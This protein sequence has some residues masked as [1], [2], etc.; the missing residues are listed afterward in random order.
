[1]NAIAVLALATVG[2]GDDG[3]DDDDDNGDSDAAPSVQPPLSL[4]GFDLPG[5]ALFPEGIAVA[6]DGT[7]YVGSLAEG[8]VIRLQ[9]GETEPDV[10][11]ATGEP[12]TRD[13]GAAVGMIVDEDM[14]VLWVCDAGDMGMGLVPSVIVGFALADGSV[15]ARHTLPDEIGLC[16][17]LTLDGAGNLYASD[18][19]NPRLIRVPAGLR[20]QD[21]SAEV[22]ATRDD[23]AVAPGQFGLNGLDVVGSV[24]YAGHTQNRAVYSVPI[25]AGDG[26]AG[27][28]AEI[29]LDSRPDGIDGMKVAG[30]GSLLL[31]DGFGDNISRVELDGSGG[32]T[33]SVIV[34]D[35]D[36]PT[37]FAFHGDSAWIVEGQLPHLFDPELGPPNLPFKVIRQVLDAGLVP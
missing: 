18:S 26:A 13:I 21:N 17:D 36:G 20:M 37:T 28:I 31:V 10:F 32:G 15:A 6:D 14:Q 25:E 4:D 23:W 8:S 5:D 1:M 19:F 11:V 3:G 16:N 9:A 33:L 12:G 22:W 30:D 29:T 2:C 35:L 7:F 27:E 34:P 24:L